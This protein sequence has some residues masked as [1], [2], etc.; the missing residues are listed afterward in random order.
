LRRFFPAK[1]G[2]PGRSGDNN[3][4]FVEGVLWD[5]AH[6]RPVARS[7]ALL[8]ELVFGVEA[9]PALGAETQPAP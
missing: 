2:D 1:E 6:G 5:R 3:R 9:L 7:A 4:M 8:R